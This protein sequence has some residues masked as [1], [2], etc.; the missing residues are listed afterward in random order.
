MKRRNILKLLAA[1]S[2]VLPLGTK[3]KDMGKLN[4]ALV[5]HRGNPT[6]AG[7]EIRTYWG[8]APLTEQTF[9]AT[10]WHNTACEIYVNNISMFY[11]HGHGSCEIDLSPFPVKPGSCV[12]C[13]DP[14]AL[15]F[16]RDFLF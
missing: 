16:R 10:V 9:S 13:S 5:A 6:G 3:L 14:T 2:M 7:F 12:R 8:S 1:V 11:S 15:V 4:G